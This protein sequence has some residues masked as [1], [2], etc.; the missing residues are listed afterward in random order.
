M[1]NTDERYKPFG[2]MFWTVFFVELEQEIL[3][4]IKPKRDGRKD[5]P[6]WVAL[7]LGRELNMS[8]ACWKTW[9][10]FHNAGSCDLYMYS[11]SLISWRRIRKKITRDILQTLLSNWPHT[12]L[13]LCPLW[14]L[15][16]RNAFFPELHTHASTFIIKLKGNLERQLG[17]TN[18]IFSER[19]M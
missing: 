4:S 19:Y 15:A 11:K 8:M 9:M 1:K 13:Y 16:R 14:F 6:T 10:I 12:L 3:V 5:D 18:F 2:Y 7:D 17:L